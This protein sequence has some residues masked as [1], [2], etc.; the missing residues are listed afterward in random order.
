MKSTHSH[1]QHKQAAA[2]SYP[3]SGKFL[4]EL[5]ERVE[6]ATAIVS[7]SPTA[8]EKLRQSILLYLDSR[9]VPPTNEAPEV[10]LAFHLLK[11]EIDKAISRSEAARARAAK[12]REE[13][14]EKAVSTPEAP[15]D[16]SEKEDS[17]K[18]EQQTDSAEFQNQSVVKTDVVTRPCANA[19]PGRKQRS[20]KRKHKRRSR[21]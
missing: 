14:A 15:C 4:R 12:R 18:K 11:P 13:K 1:R 16:A 10:I 2:L 5:M 6:S 8:S 7:L 21:R 3:V 17:H 9:A 20:R 19:A